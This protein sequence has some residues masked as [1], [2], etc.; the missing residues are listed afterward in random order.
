MKIMKPIVNSRIGKLYNVIIPFYDKASHRVLVK[1]RPCMILDEPKGRDKE[2]VILPISSSLNKKYYNECFD[3]LLCKDDYPKLELVKDSYLRTHKQ[4]TAYEP[5]I[6][7]KRCLG[8]L[9]EDYSDTFIMILDKVK[10]YD[11]Y[12]IKSSR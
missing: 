7:F 9:K 6:D 5:N 12:K 1:A 10:E 4:T 3:V 8:D 11:E 2:Y